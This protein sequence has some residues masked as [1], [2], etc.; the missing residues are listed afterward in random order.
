MQACKAIDAQL[1]QLQRQIQKPEADARESLED[2]SERFCSSVS[3]LLKGSIAISASVH[4][5]T[6]EQE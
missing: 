1:Q 4:G 2:F 5:E 3:A 6:L